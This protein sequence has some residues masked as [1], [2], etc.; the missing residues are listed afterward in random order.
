MT[1]E[2]GALYPC[3]QQHDLRLLRHE[4][5]HLLDHGNMEVLGDV[6]FLALA[7][8]PRQRQD[9]ALDHARHQGT[10]VCLLCVAQEMKASVRGVNLSGK[11]SLRASFCRRTN[12]PLINQLVVPTML[13]REKVSD[14][15]SPCY[16]GVP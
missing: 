8:Q 12:I 5:F 3:A 7:Y 13:G 2:S 1:R 10:I 6:D 11:M 4:L 14:S 9:A 15:E 16:R